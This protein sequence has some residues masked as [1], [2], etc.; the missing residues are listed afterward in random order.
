MSKKPTLKSRIS[1]LKLNYKTE[2][3]KIVVL[4]IIC[5]L[6]GFICFLIFKKIF[7]LLCFTCLS[8]VLIFL[9]LNS[10]KE[11]ERKIISDHDEEFVHF[12]TY[13][14]I[15]MSN[16]FNVYCSLEFAKK[17]CSSWM[18]EKI[19]ILLKEIDEDKSV[20]PF[21]NFA[22]NFNNLAYESVVLTIYQI[23]DDGSSMLYFNKFNSLFEKIN[24]EHEMKMLDR[25]KRTVDTLN[26]FPIIGASLITVLLLFGILGM[27]GDLINGF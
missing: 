7:Y 6:I 12:F 10:Y 15:Y 20:Q 2:I 14:Q 4:P 18:E 9:T 24:K 5:L 11:K 8:L 16:G 19:S 22:N 3:V 21:V 23:I 26:S 27:I 1:S 17:D 25:K 13:F